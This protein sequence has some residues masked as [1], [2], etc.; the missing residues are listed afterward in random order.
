MN[1]MCEDPSV[2]VEHLL[3]EV[4]AED[5]YT[6]FVR[7]EGEVESFPRLNLL[8]EA[9]KLLHGEIDCWRGPVGNGRRLFGRGG[10]RRHG[11]FKVSVNV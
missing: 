1:A 5:G 3:D 10:G 4:N 6:L 8:D 7:N 11:V 2:L 9:R